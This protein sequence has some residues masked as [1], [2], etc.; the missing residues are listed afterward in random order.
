MVRVFDEKKSQAGSLL[1]EAMAM[2]GLI[3]MVTPMLY[4]KA[5]ERTTE[6]QDINAAGQ[7][8]IAMDAI[9]TYLSDN[10]NTIIGLGDQS[11]TVT[12]NCS[13]STSS[14]TYN[15]DGNGNK[16]VPIEHFCEYL[17]YGFNASSK[18]FKNLEV[19]IKKRDFDNDE[20]H[21][22][23][24]LL[25]TTPAES[26]TMPI[27]R[28]SRI[29]SMI[30]TNAGF[31]KD[32][33]IQ[34]VQGVWDID[35]PSD[36]GLNTSQLKDNTIVATSI[37]AITNGNNSGENVLHRVRMEEEPWLNT[38]ETTLYMGDDLSHHSI[39]NV[40]QMIV[41]GKGLDDKD[42]AILLKDG[43][44]LTIET[45]GAGN[46]GNANIGGNLDVGGTA[47][48]TGDTNVGGNL[49]VAGDAKIEGHLE[50]LTATITNLLTA[51]SAEIKG[52][53]TAGGGNFKVDDTGNT[54]I[55]ANLTVEGTS[56][57]KQLVV[58]PMP[59][60]Y[61]PYYKLDVNGP[62]RFRDEVRFDEPVDMEDLDVKNQLRVGCQQRDAQ[63]NCVGDYNL[64]VDPD[65][66]RILVNNF[67]VGDPD[68]TGGFYVSDELI[69]MK[70]DEVYADTTHF[71]VGDGTGTLIVD[72]GLDG[73]S[74]TVEVN[75][76]DMTVNN[77][78][79]TVKD[80]LDTSIFE[81]DPEAKEV[82]VMNDA[83]FIASSAAGD[84]IFVIDTN[85]TDGTKPDASIYVR[86]GVIEIGRNTDESSDHSDPNS[87]IK[88]DRLIS[89]V[90]VDDNAYQAAYI[91]SSGKELYDVYQVNPAYTSVMHDIKLITRGGARLS[92]ILPDFINKG[93][94]VLD[95]TY[96]ATK[97]CTAGGESLNWLMAGDGRPDNSGSFPLNTSSLFGSGVIATQSFVKSC[98]STTFKCETSPWLGFVPAPTCPPGYLKVATLSPISW[99]MAQAGHPVEK[100]SGAR[101]EIELQINRDPN[102]LLWPESDAWD[103][104]DG[105]KKALTFQ[106]STWL[107]TSFVSVK[108]TGGTS[109]GWNAA[110]GFLYPAKD[111]RTYANEI[112]LGSSWSDDDVIWNLFEVWN[113][114]I[115][116]IS[117]VYCYFNRRK[118]KN[119]FLN[120]NLVDRYDQLTKVRVGYDSKDSGYVNRL[121]DPT[122]KYDDPF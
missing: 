120:D 100:T 106:K 113:R 91:T 68:G 25:V 63:G 118:E 10:Y 101:N 43:S 62:A 89:N 2:L 56:N 16:V 117:N 1:I 44:G 114:Q 45:D 80:N 3:A 86:K 59:D 26:Q 110:I 90:E 76:A 36:F 94:Y 103:T 17:P 85:Y 67:M 74:P 66:V 19:V 55:N 122:L 31:V 7:I 115:V 35:K 84:D 29:A 109:Y 39:E 30:G 58:G 105:Y 111:Y 28:A 20:R 24:G 75:D 38:M 119:D 61:D 33:K 6:L 41:T 9:D 88:V 48:I 72:S 27:L 73:L 53:L 83:N 8:R 13:G 15:F 98:P 40:K 112:G 71:A 77:G 70:A 108:D 65:E 78:L 21:D 32:K 87:Y 121:N 18:T 52:S 50:A 14:V 23:T 81:V 47:D 12:S 102:S 116:G 92:D 64:L 5:A 79:L 104:Y 60:D 4:K 107:N 46:G 22:L 34:G 99:S 97:N 57:L 37:R 95:G 93:I 54:T 11:K 42:Q 69:K 51:G 82:K 96:C 49:N